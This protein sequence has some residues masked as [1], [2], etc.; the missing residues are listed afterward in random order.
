[1]PESATDRPTSATEKMF[2][3]TKQS[4]YFYDADAVRES[5]TTP[6]HALGGAN[7][8]PY[9]AYSENETT[10]RNLR[11][12]WRV[13]GE[14]FPDAHF[15]TFGTKW[16]EPCIKA[17]TSERGSCAEC[18]SPWERVVEKGD[19]I[20]TGHTSKD[21]PKYKIDGGG[22][23]GAKVF[24]SVPPGMAYQNTTLG[25]QPTCKCTFMCDDN[26]VEYQGDPI[27]CLV[28]DPF[29]GSGTVGVV[30]LKLGRS[31]VGL[32]LKAEYTEMANK[33]VFNSGSL[34]A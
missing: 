15:A 3:L 22:D 13:V 16:I 5:A 28:L 1:M 12:W 9:Q 27:P 6:W 19:L 14:P 33:R 31:F 18:G 34:L 26:V 32:E 11:N 29:A 2:L 17:G 30:C 10:G 7:K 23:R 20:Q 25:W 24:S 21:P 4:K 8:G